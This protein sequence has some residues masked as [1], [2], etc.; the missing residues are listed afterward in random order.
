MKKKALRLAKDKKTAIFATRYDSNMNFL[1]NFLMKH[2]LILVL[3]FD[4][5]SNNNSSSSSNINSNSSSNSNSNHKTGCLYNKPSHLTLPSSYDICCRG[6]IP[7]SIPNVL[8][9]G[10]ILSDRWCWFI[11]LGSGLLSTHSG[12]ISLCNIYPSE[13]IWA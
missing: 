9:P 3:Q 10:Q 12:E 1:A 13:D 7:T 11:C 5:N 8:S 4:I 2:S 6:K